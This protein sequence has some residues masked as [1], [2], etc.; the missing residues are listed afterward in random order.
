M[1][2]PDVRVI[3]SEPAPDGFDARRDALSRT[4]RYRVLTRRAASPFERGRALHGPARSTAARSIG[5]RRR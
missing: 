2:P 1:L 3:E 5:A 4:Y